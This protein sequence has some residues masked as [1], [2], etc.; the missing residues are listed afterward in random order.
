M[1]LFEIIIVLEPNLRAH[2]AV[3]FVCSILVF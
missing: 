1:Q 2:A 3:K